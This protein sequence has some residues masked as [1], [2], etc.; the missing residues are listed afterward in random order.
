MSLFKQMGFT[1]AVID[2]IPYS[3]KE[4]LV[5]ADALEFYWRFRDESPSDLIF[6]HVL[7]AFYHLGR[8]GRLEV[9]SGEESILGALMCRADTS[10]RK[11]SVNTSVTSCSSVSRRSL[12]LTGFTGALRPL[13][14]RTLSPF[15]AW[16][17]RRWPF[18]GR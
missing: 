4:D 3:T 2:R 18:T 6:T 11:V 8:S 1:D 15:P 12:K 7:H 10:I 9:R 16:R 5:D 13:T 14:T 17:G